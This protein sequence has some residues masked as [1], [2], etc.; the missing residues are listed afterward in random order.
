[1]RR[2]AEKLPSANDRK[3]ALDGANAMRIRL[4]CPEIT[5]EFPKERP[6]SMDA[7]VR[8]TLDCVERMTEAAPLTCCPKAYAR[9]EEACEAMRYRGRR[10]NK[11]LAETLPIPLSNRLVRGIDLIDYAYNSRTA[12]E[13]AARK[14]KG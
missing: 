2:E 13:Y 5:N 8:T 14:A 6:E 9:R 1:M 12:A 3:A 11:W 4:G 10:E 7:A